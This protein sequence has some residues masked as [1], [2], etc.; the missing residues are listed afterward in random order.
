MCSAV[1]PDAWRLITAMRTPMIPT[2]AGIV[3]KSDIVCSL[4]EFEHPLAAERPAD[5]VREGAEVGTREVALIIPRVEMVRDVEHLQAD[6]GVVMKQAEPLADLHVERDEG[7]IAA[8]LVA[9]TD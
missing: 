8:R 2:P 5:A 1:T 3:N 9:R 6:R 4:L 7:G